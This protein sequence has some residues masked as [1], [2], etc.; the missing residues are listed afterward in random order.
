MMKRWLALP[1]LALSLAACET[2][3]VFAPAAHEGGVGYT[4]SRIQD[5]R[6]RVTFHGGSNAGRDR[7]HDLVLLRAAQLTL[8][9]GYDWFEVVAG[10]G[11][12]EPYHGPTLSVGGGTSN[13]GWHGGSSFGAGVEGI[14]LGGGPTMTETVEIAMA[15]GA[16][17]RQPNAYDA[18][19]IVR[20]IQ[21]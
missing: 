2:P 9:S 13:Y 15:K 10:Y 17:P 16:P 19:Q 8:S 12:A 21:P 4:E 20:S 3:T 5:D 18:H 11:E 1:L 7:V 14:P 6:Y